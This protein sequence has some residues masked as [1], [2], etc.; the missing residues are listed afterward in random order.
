MVFQS[1]NTDVGEANEDMDI[2]YHGNRIE[3]GYNID[4]LIDATEV[5]DEENIYFEI[6]EGRRPGVIR[7]T[8]KE[9]YLC[10]IMPLMI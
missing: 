7:S 9:E 8:N 10:V 1:K 4:Y 6:G 2:T 5:I 3:V